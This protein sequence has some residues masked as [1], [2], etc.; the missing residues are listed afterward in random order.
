MSEPLASSS[1]PQALVS[2]V[3]PWPPTLRSK[4]KLLASSA[5]PEGEQLHLRMGN[6]LP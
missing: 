2:E 6:W 1:Q 3:T 4:R 5:R